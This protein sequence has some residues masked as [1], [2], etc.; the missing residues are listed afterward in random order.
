MHGAGILL[1]Q[2]LSDQP[3]RRSRRSLHPLGRCRDPQGRQGGPHGPVPRGVEHRGEQGLHR[4]RGPLLRGRRAEYRTLAGTACPPA[5]A[6]RRGFGAA[7]RAPAGR[8]CSSGAQLRSHSAA[9]PS[10][11]SALSHRDAL[12]DHDSCPSRQYSQPPA[13]RRGGRAGRPEGVRAS[14]VRRSARRLVSSG[15]GSA[16]RVGAWLH[17][18]TVGRARPERQAHGREPLTGLGP[19]RRP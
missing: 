6:L 15:R 7:S 3:D 17:A 19:G 18:P 5:A 12:G 4:E 16:L 14:R 2:A 10:L 13:R 11:S 1:T 9:A 8:P